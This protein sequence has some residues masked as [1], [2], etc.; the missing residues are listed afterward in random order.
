VWQRQEIQKLSRRKRV[1]LVDTIKRIERAD[2]IVFLGAALSGVLMALAFAPFDMADAAWCCLVPLLISCSYAKPCHAIKIG[3][4]TGTIFW[5][6]TL[7]WLTKVTFV[8]LLILSLYCA[9]YVAPF[10]LVAV[11]WIRTH[12]AGRFLHNAA[13]MIVIT[14]VWVASEFARVTFFTGFP[15]NPLGVSQYQ[16]VMLI[17]HASWGG[18]Y[19]ISGILVWVNAA[20]ALTILRY[21]KKLARFGRSTHPE[22]LMGMTVILIAFVTGN[23]MYNQ[24]ELPGRETRIALIQP[25]IPQYDKWSEE[26]EEMIY[27]RLQDLTSQSILWTTPDL[28]VWPETALPYDVK[29]SE[30]CYDLVYS[31]ARMGSPILVGSMDSEIRYDQKPLYYN[32]SFLFDTN[33]IIIEEYQKRHLVLFG[34]Y[35]PFHQ[36]VDIVNAMTPVMES[37]TPGST[38][39]V[40][41]V[42]ERKMPFSALICFEDSLPYL[43]RHSVRNG[44][45]ML[46]NQTNDAWFDPSSASR[47]HMAMSVF[48][49]VENRVPMVRSANT[50]YTC[51]INA[52]GQ[53]QRVLMSE[54]GQ[55]DGPGFHLAVVNIPPDE[56]PLTFYTR[57]GDVFAWVC[58]AIGLTAMVPAVRSI[59]KQNA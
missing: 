34:E 49:A 53:I 35:V 48:R 25:A 5:L 17:Q 57:H 12:G 4:T 16:N 52:R 8:G 32:S 45:R 30:Y 55:H 20:I 28:V 54:N 15:W 18:V 38:S 23:K 33:G 39:T 21:L 13:F 24:P 42:P 27:Q 1:R 58:F 31:L 46:I 6:I 47:Q 56:M 37:F 11:W 40:F 41:Q 26:K 10:T 51:E 22:M 50:G 36:Y 7:F 2:A 59:R 3:I 9:L 43:A 14:A 44:A 29:Q 19:A